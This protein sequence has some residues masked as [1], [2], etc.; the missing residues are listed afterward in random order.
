MMLLSV[1]VAQRCNAMT[2][3][4]GLKRSTSGR[5]QR[6]SEQLNPLIDL[7]IQTRFGTVVARNSQLLLATKVPRVCTASHTRRATHLPALTGAPSV[8][9]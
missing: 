2:S 3:R 7:W 5:V 9:R 6:R 1:G 4:R 8:N